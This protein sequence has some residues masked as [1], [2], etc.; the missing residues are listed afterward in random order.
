M[1]NG[2]GNTE[3]D[4][5]VRSNNLTGLTD[6]PIVRSNTGVDH[7]TGRTHRSAEFVS[8]FAHFSEFSFID[9]TA[10]ARQNDLGILQIRTIALNLLAADES[11]FNHRRSRNHSFEFG[12]AFSGRSGIKSC[13]TNR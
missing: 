7:R 1:L 3:T 8:Q 12:F 2:T 10:A 4:V 5:Q 9:Q 6:L 11:D 13:S